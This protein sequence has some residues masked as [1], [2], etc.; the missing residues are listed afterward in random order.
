MLPPVYNRIPGRTLTP[1]RI[2]F[3]TLVVLVLAVLIA[4]HLPSPL[5]PEDQASPPPAED[6]ISFR[7]DAPAGEIARAGGRVLEDYGAF[8][9]AQGSQGTLAALA[10][11]GRWTEALT[12]ASLVWLRG[13]TVDVRALQAP[14]A[15]ISSRAEAASIGVIHFYAPIKG[16][17]R[18]EL[19]SIGIDILRFIPRNALLVRGAASAYE[20]ARSL[21]YVDAVFP[22]DAAM[23]VS[24]STGRGGNPVEVRIVVL[25]GADPEAVRAWLSHQG[26]PGREV[27]GPFGSGEF[28]WIRAR[29]TAALVTSLAAL[30]QVEFIEPV[31]R[32]RLMNAETAWVI[33]TNES[34]GGAGDYRYWTYGLDGR[35]EFVGIADTGVDYDHIGFRESLASIA[36]GDLYNTTDASRRK[37]VRY[38]NMGVLG[39]RITWPGGGGP[40][41]PWSIQDS[42]HWTFAANCTFGHGTAAASTLA[43]NDDWNALGGVNDGNAKGAQLY[44]QDIGTVGPGEL[45]ALGDED[46]LAY[47]PEDLADLLGPAG[48]VYHDPAAPVRIHSDSWGTDTNE[49]D[50]QA[51][52]IDAFVWSHPDLVV[53]FP[54]GNAGPSPSTVGSPGTAKNIVTAG[55]AGNPDLY[56]AS[57]DQDDLA[58]LSGRGPTADGRIKPT[59]ITIFDGDSQMSDGDAGSGTGVADDHW[60]GTSYSTP[61]AAAAAAI[62][63]QYF[64]EGWYPT[65]APVAGNGRNPSAA[66]VRAM[67][68]ASTEQMT[69]SESSRDDTWP[70]FEQGFGRVRLANVL[71]IAAEADPF[72]LHVVESSS[73]LLTGDASEYA[74]RVASGG[75]RVRVVLAWSDYPAAPGAAKALVN[76]LDLELVA[77]DG[78]VYRGNNFGRM[79]EASSVPGGSFDVTNVEEAVFLPAAIEGVWTVRV[80]GSDVPV[81]PQPFALVAVGALDGGY[82]RV[83]LERPI[84]SGADV[85]RISVEDEGAS[86]VVVTAASDFEPAGEAL[87][88][89]GSATA[90][91][92]Q[93]SLPTAF[94]PAAA[95]GVLQVRH[96]DSIEVRYADASPAHVAVAVARVDAAPPAVSEVSADRIATMSAR[97]RWLTD[98]PALAEVRYG[99]SPAFLTLV[100]TAGDLRTAHEIVL[101]NLL[102]DTRYYFDVL[103]TDRLGQ[104]TLD[105]NAGRHYALQ[106]PPLGDIVLV[107][108]DHTFPPER[109]DS[110]RSA[111]AARGWLWS[112]WRV[113]DSG[114]P[115]LDFLRSHRAVV[116]QVGLERYPPFN[117]TEQVLLQTY[118]D[119][120]GR[121]L[122]SAHD[123]VWALADAES[124]FYRPGFAA[125]ARGVLKA[126]L[127]CD[128]ADVGRLEG[129]SND[130]ISGAHVAGVRYGAHRDGGAVDE[131]VL[132]SA[133]G[134]TVEVW[135]DDQVTPGTCGGE[136]VGHRWVSSAANGTLG[137]G[138]WGGTPSRLAFFAFELTGL[139]ATPTDLATNSTTR[140][141]VL[142]DALRWL[143]GTSTTTLDRDHPDITITSPNGGM[144]TG[145]TLSVTWT[146]SV[147]G[148]AFAGFDLYASDD[149]GQT[150]TGIGTAGPTLRSFDWNITSIPNGDR[151]LVRVLARDG[152]IPMLRGQDETDAPMTI[153]RPGG[154][155]LGP[156]ILAGSVGGT[157][158]PPGAAASVTFFAAA[159]DRAAGGAAIGGGELFFGATPPAPAENGTGVP[160]EAADGAFDEPLEDVLWSGPLPLPPGP[161]CMWIHARDAPGNWGDYASMCFTAL[162][163]GPD[164]APPAR[165]SVLSAALANARADVELTW[166]RALDEGLFGGTVGYAVLRFREPAT[167]V[168]NASWT[169]PADGSGT[170]GFVDGGAGEGDP[171]D[172][173]Y[174]IETVDAAGNR[175]RSGL[176]A[177]VRIAVGQGPNLLG[178]P[179]VL[180]DPSLS[181]ITGGL[182]WSDGWTY[183][184]CG[185]GWTS[186]T[187]LDAGSLVIGQGAGFWLNATAP[188]TLLVVGFVSEDRVRPATEVEL[189]AGW[190][191]VAVPGFANLTVAMVKAATGAD[192]IASADPARAFGT[193]TLR[194]DERLLPGRGYWVHVMYDVVWIVSG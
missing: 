186:A 155:L 62:I 74:F 90:A 93:G 5:P 19:E 127:R 119:G 21:P 179:V 140:A 109:E 125:W 130:P 65:G 16:A 105:S 6:W 28:Q 24:P 112:V 173:Y 142:D 77:P 1:F 147:E 150:W 81:G 96:G 27:L 85:L 110:Y 100:A 154:D 185:G 54:S 180:A 103:A 144:F 18:A 177:K 72:R 194:D 160:M 87:V 68:I 176:A 149:L 114:P 189:C 166:A 10:T 25:P 143:I 94:G 47:I 158:N 12:G 92:W 42:R 113:A 98:E 118:L 20:A 133:G 169:I 124:P 51:R 182:T 104:G 4:L 70:N 8:S 64:A 11:R 40:W 80:F 174:R 60:L 32:P 57:E 36:L 34:F 45:C 132:I 67:L 126:G 122:V 97:V 76:D 52:M 38:L 88:L 190:N 73:G 44:V 181:A 139:D 37:V 153:A 137:T 171:S 13:G 178:M 120:G 188:G 29:V 41:D 39:D 111:L 43:G 58:A 56:D 55:G 69:G 107:I 165:A 134:S 101:T 33:Q 61:A 141:T 170:Y 66:L 123:A 48:L 99:S 135:R 31:H 152:G 192:A 17:W 53:V 46:L 168:L 116:W 86:A 71:R 3:D 145:P 22:Y 167:L 175:A 131:L 108:G 187:P 82:G 129:I 63:R 161:S 157:P 91:T 156:M 138:T 102:P 136:P 2:P 78:T 79:A 84:V 59:V 30:P 121:L 9:V 35:G 148:A 193:I 14:T 146:A 83:S 7:T 26:V 128:P 184:G 15:A 49:Y 151:Y 95:D 163:A 162:D 183:D 23:K 159:D 89:T 106:T 115:P 172:Y 50:L 191:L 75:G 117:Q 164:Q